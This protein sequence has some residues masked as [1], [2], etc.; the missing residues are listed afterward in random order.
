MA[1]DL[2]VPLFVIAQTVF[3]LIPFFSAL[4]KGLHRRLERDLVVR[5]LHY[6]AAWVEPVVHTLMAPW[7]QWC[8]AG[9][10][11]ALEAS[12]RT[13]RLIWD[14]LDSV[15]VAQHAHAIPPSRYSVL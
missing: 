9:L 14:A 1:L 12:Q 3:E 5:G 8:I 11:S 7:L 10:S 15:L 6:V 4:S 13:I 2:V